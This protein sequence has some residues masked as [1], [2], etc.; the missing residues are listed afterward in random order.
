MDHAGVPALLPEAEEVAAAIRASR[1]RIDTAAQFGRVTRPGDR[2]KEMGVD[3]RIG[4]LCLGTDSRP[5][6]PNLPTFHRGPDL[7]LLKLKKSVPKNH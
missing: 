3:L 1:E 2:L 6:Q 4:P 5:P 7:H